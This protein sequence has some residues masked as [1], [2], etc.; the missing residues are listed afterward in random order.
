LR[1]RDG[2]VRF[3]D[4]ACE[5]F[6]AGGGSMVDRR[7]CARRG[8]GR[9]RGGN[10]GS[11]RRGRRGARG[12]AAKGQKPHSHEHAHGQQG[13]LKR[14]RD[15]GHLPMLRH[16]EQKVEARNGR[17][18]AWSGPHELRACAQARITSSPAGILSRRF[19]PPAGDFSKDGGLSIAA[20]W[21][22]PRVSCGGCF[23]AAI[24]R[25][26]AEPRALGHVGCPPG[27]AWRAR[28]AGC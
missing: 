9:R 13:Y 2:A 16:L 25:A 1:S 3:G 22:G 8:G 5:P 7:R 15:L 6:D 21:S 24:C 4:R 17:W 14:A 28:P 19:S 11:R 27:S 18:T 10:R 12:V 20:T 23:A 26:G